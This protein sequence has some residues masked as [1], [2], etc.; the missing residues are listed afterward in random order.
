G[1]LPDDLRAAI[2][3]HLQIVSEDVLA[4]LRIA[5]A[6]GDNFSVLT[7]AALTGEMRRDLPSWRADLSVAAAHGLIRG[8]SAGSYRFVHALIREHLYL[9][10][11]AEEQ[12]HAHAAI[13]RALTRLALSRPCPADLLAHHYMRGWPQL[14]TGDVVEH[15]THA[16]QAAAAQ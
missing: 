13:A 14:S 1:D 3:A 12:T 4:T 10:L 2:D 16:A 8:D 7:L 5:A 6:I 9:Q 15:L 11:S